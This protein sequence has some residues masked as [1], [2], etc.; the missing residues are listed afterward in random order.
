LAILCIVDVGGKTSEQNRVIMREATH[1]V[2]LSRDKEKISD[3]Q[4]FC[5]SLGL[6]I[7][8]VIYS[9]IDGKEDVIE[10]EAPVLTG[11]VHRLVRGEDVSGREMVKALARLLVNT[12]RA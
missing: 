5:E 7:I 8:A 4:E 12:S 9:D 11:S 3:W 10:E 1:A 2:I 6:R